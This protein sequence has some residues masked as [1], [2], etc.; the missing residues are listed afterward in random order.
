MS[1]SATEPTIVNTWLELLPDGSC[2]SDPEYDNDFQVDLANAANG[3]ASSQFQEG[4]PPNW[5]LV[6]SITEN[7]FERTRD[8]RVAVYWAR[9]MLHLEGAR[10]LGD[11]LRL[12]HGLLDRHWDVV[13]PV[14]EDG[15]A[16]ARVNALNDMCSAAGL[17]G[18]LRQSMVVAN[19][20]IGEMTGRDLEIVLGSL[21]PRSDES[22][23]TRAQA[24]QMLALATSAD[25]SLRE[26]PTAA[27]A[28]LEK[29]NDLMR[30]KVGY[31]SAPNLEPLIGIM[32][33]LLDL[34]PSE[35]SG[36]TGDLLADV[37]IADTGAPA[38]RA[39]GGG[40][41]SLSG[42]IATRQDALKAIDMVCDY[43]E[44]TEPTNPAQLLL[45]RARKLVDK[46]FLE[47]VREFAPQSV[48]EVARILGVSPDD[49]SG[50]SY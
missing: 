40:R 7:L 30:E 45:R 14:P 41:Q 12:I 49:S 5:R 18:D 46:N 17:L 20:S 1:D 34:M 22:P 15:D 39:A 35:G 13:H 16:W 37:G 50:S 10:S 48:D 27:L 6:R 11:S 8:V 38:A 25:P 19:R 2:G 29:L 33:G 43:L 42:E 3:K 31:G 44:R 9:A 26:F 24:E 21:E 32:R 36:D 47:L 4:E 28:T 23:M